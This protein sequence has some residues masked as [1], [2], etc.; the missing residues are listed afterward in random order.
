MRRSERGEIPA[1]ARTGRDRAPARIIRKSEQTDR[2]ERATDPRVQHGR[3]GRRDTPPRVPPG[4]A[5]CQTPGLLGLL[6]L[7]AQ[8]KHPSGSRGRSGW[9]LL[10]ILRV[11]APSGW[12]EPTPWKP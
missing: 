7:P 4:A 9:S 6:G 1:R 12:K 10:E 11:S 5:S 2:T 3:N 8:T